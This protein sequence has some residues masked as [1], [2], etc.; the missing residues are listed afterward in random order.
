MNFIIFFVHNRG[1][2]LSTDIVIKYLNSNP[3]QK[4][5]PT[6]L[7]RLCTIFNDDRYV[8]LLP[9]FFTLLV[10]NYLCTFKVKSQT[11][12]LIAWCCYHNGGFCNDCITQRCLHKLKNVS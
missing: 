6:F 4:G 8:T 3:L 2:E 9:R 7:A 1:G 10:T 12:K 5:N 11:S